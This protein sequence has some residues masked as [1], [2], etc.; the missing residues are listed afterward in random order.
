MQIDVHASKSQRHNQTEMKQ[1]CPA[2]LAHFRG[3]GCSSHPAS[4]SPCPLQHVSIETSPDPEGKYYPGQKQQGCV[5]IISRCWGGGSRGPRDQDRTGE[6][7]RGALRW[8]PTDSSNLP[9]PPNRALTSL[10]WEESLRF[11]PMTLAAPWWW[12]WWVSSDALFWL[13]Q[14]ALA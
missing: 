9:P 4:P 6:E 1:R 2:P 7:S 13:K 8:G 5:D 10:S 14:S 11:K 3:G 12:W